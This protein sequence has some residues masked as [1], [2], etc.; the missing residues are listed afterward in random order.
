MEVGMG[1]QG[2]QKAVIIA[3]CAGLSSLSKTHGPS[4][5]AMIEFA[6]FFRDQTRASRPD[7]ISYRLQA[8]TTGALSK[9]SPNSVILSKRQDDG[10]HDTATV[11]AV[12]RHGVA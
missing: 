5:H 1:G 8:A 2:Q 4:A 6:A 12:L 3:D 11:V 9:L 7:L 10:N